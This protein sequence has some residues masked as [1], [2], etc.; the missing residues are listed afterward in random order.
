VDTALIRERPEATVAPG[1]MVDAIVVEPWAAHPSDSYGYYYRDLRHYALYGEM[2]RTP[3]GF[4]RYVDEWIIR[5]GSHAGLLAKLGDE[6]L[7]GLRVR[8]D[9][10]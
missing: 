10:S 6:A 8:R 2:S 4:E 5:P 1:F 3:E 9:C 7:A